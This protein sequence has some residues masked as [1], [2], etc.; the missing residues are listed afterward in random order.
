MIKKVVAVVLCVVGVVLFVNAPEAHSYYEQNGNGYKLVTE[1]TE[2]C[3]YI[4][5]DTYVTS[6]GNQW[7]FSDGKEREITNTYKIT[8]SDKATETV[9]DDI[10][11]EVK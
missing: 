3:V 1:R 9:R 2:K 7:V 4:G 5:N 11:K 8:I 6:D 10:V